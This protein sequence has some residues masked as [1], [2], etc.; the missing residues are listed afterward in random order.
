[1][2]FEDKFV[3]YVN[4]TRQMLYISASEIHSPCKGCE[5]DHL[6]M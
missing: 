3:N 1:M 6:Q 4:I 5:L 2:Q